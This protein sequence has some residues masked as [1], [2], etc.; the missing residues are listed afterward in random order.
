MLGVVGGMVFGTFVA[1]TVFGVV[2]GTISMFGVVV[3]VLGGTVTG[4]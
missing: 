1:G 4:G 2:D 3:G